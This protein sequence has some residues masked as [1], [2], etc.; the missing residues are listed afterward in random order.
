MENLI[1]L[2]IKINEREKFVGKV[3]DY[4]SRELGLLR[5][6]YREG[7][8]HDFYSHKTA[9]IS[10]DKAAADCAVG[11]ENATFMVCYCSDTKEL[12]IVP[13]ATFSRVAVIDLG[14]REQYRVPLGAF[15]KFVDAVPLELGFTNDIVRFD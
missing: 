2:A 15:K 8:F 1:G 7:H 12:Y 3:G 9:S 4:Q 14:E 5:I 10:I 11:V 13:T 6:L